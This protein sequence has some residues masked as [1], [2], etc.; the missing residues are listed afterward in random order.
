MDQ[1]ALEE[2]EERAIEKEFKSKLIS[3]HQT[4][5]RG[6]KCAFLH[7]GGSLVYFG[8]SKVPGE[9]A[10]FLKRQLEVLHL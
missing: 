8:L 7:K 6:M 2:A 10:E 1:Q 3:I 4:N 5:S 9:S